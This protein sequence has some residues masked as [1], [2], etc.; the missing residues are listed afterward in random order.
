MFRFP[1]NLKATT[2][3]INTSVGVVLELPLLDLVSVTNFLGN[4]L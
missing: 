3:T 2:E 4:N 1:E